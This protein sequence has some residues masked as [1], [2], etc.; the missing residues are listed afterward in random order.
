MP[1]C[2][3][4]EPYQPHSVP[5]NWGRPTLSQ[6]AQN[7]VPSPLSPPEKASIPKLKYEALDV[8]EVRG[9]CE[10]RVLMHYSYF[11]SL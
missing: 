11:G 8:S 10:R 5:P 2:S 9:P 1:L 6:G 7:S 3:Y 4:P